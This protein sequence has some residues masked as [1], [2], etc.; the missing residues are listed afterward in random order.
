MDT[1]LLVQTDRSRYSL[2]DIYDSVSI[3][4]DIQEGDLSNFERRSNYSKTFRV[5]ATDNNNK[6]FKFFF[7]VNGT[8]YNPFNSLPCVVQINGNDIFTGTLRLDGVYINN[9]YEE[10]EVY[11][12][13]ELVDFTASLGEVKVKDIDFTEYNHSVNYDNI[14][15]SWSA[16]TGNTAGLFGGDIIYPMINYGLAYSG[17][18]PEF[19]YC[20]GSSPCFSNSS[21][22]LP[23]YIW[24]PSMRLK[25]IVD[26]IFNYAGFTYTSNFFNS[27]Y[28]KLLY[29]DLGY[30]NVLGIST[31]NELENLNFFL[32]YSPSQVYT[33]YNLHSNRTS[34]PFTTLDPNG[35][36]YLNNYQL[37]Q[38]TSTDETRLNY[39]SIPK[40]GTYSFAFRA[41]YTKVGTLGEDLRMTITAR[42]STSVEGLKNGTIIGTTTIDADDTDQQLLFTFSASLTNTEYV[43]LFMEG[44]LAGAGFNLFQTFIWKPYSSSY[45]APLFTC[46]SSPVM[47]STDFEANKNLPDIK[48]IDFLKSIVKTFNLIIKVDNTKNIV[49]EP[50]DYYFES[51]KRR[52]K[53]WTNK[54][55]V[56]NSYSIKPFSFELPKTN[57]YTY[58]SAENEVNGRYYEYQF[59]QIFGE[60]VIDKPSNILK[61]E[62]DLDIIFRPT[63][64][65]CI[66]GSDWII[67]PEFY[68]VSDEGLKVPTTTAPHLFFWL[69]NRYTYTSYSASTSS[70][71]Y[72]KSGSTQV[73]WST[74]PC[75]S[76]LSG[77]ISGASSNNISDLNFR[78][79]WD[80]FANNNSYITQ[81]TG[82]HL[83]NNFHKQLYN[84]KY[85]EEARKLEG[86]FYLTPTDI[87]NFD[88][89]DRIWVKDAFYRIERISGA[90][91][92]DDK[93]TDVVL[94]KEL[95][96]GFV[97]NESPVY[98]PTIPPNNPIP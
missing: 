73:Q 76:H 67:I 43:G 96:G 59:N 9:S 32:V 34:I 38:N 14:T 37:S 49:I 21:R 28:F 62:S 52:V 93:L 55:D 94:I 6:I 61:G 98:N 48:A 97:W 30:D 80:F 64:T 47:G 7:E 63:P 57:N 25:A 40:S 91:L 22:A 23:E 15:A 65:D 17:T 89:R 54:L 53:D 24:R 92:T 78:G 72:M 90:S 58:S 41:A 10:Y 82:N 68:E 45:P 16:T 81:F 69:G 13:Q 85:S 84:E 88:I 31:A 79:H 2:I 75:V 29:T 33:G 86:K 95:D 46:V 1:L 20:I 44:V 71:W 26:K 51:D 18:S 56:G 83:F 60:N 27:P 74:Y 3:E 50:F 4:V 70:S 19:D 12:L 8:D 77:L 35:Y 66:S 42:K 39:F 87:G 5:P 36:D 11:I